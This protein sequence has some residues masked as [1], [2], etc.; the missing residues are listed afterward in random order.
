MKINPLVF[1]TFYNLKNTII[2]KIK[3][4]SCKSHKGFPQNHEIF[5]HILKLVLLLKVLNKFLLMGMNYTQ[6]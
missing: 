6:I 5:K 2:V 4:L 3:I 1:S